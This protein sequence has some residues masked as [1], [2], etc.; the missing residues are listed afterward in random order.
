MV[1]ACVKDI[2]V[3]LLIGIFIGLSL[4]FVSP[5]ILVPL[6]VVIA[7]LIFGIWLIFCIEPE[8][9]TILVKIFTAGLALRLTLCILFAFVSC[10][11]R[12]HVFFLGADDYGFSLNASRIVAAWKDTGYIPASNSLTWM[13]VAGDLNYSYL[14]SYLYYF[15]GE[16]HFMPL[17]INCSLG[18]LS[19]ILIY[20]LAKKIYSYKVAIGTALFFAFWPSLVLWSTQNLKES[21]TIFI[22]L[23]VF[24]CVRELRQ[25]YSRITYWVLLLSS[26]ALIFKIRFSL[27]VFLSLSAYVS[28]FLF[29]GRKQLLLGLFGFFIVYLFFINNWFD[30]QTTLIRRFSLD[31]S[32]ILKT[33][34]HHHQAKTVSAESAFLT[35]IDISKPL[36]FISYLPLFLLYIFFSPFPWS[37]Y[38]L[39]QLFAGLEMLVWYFLIIF[40]LKG[41][42]LTLRYKL[43]ESLMLLFFSLMVLSAS[44]GEGNIGTLFRHRALIWPCLFIFISVGL[45]YHPQKDTAAYLSTDK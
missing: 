2:L 27:F 40:A 38:K 24:W 36:N 26:L 41:L 4:V 33:F 6:V 44:F 9:P 25:S 15:I 21:I 14:L 12:G 1:K 28:L 16:Y 39:N 3:F 32:S 45:F 22:I 29:S 17:F 34:Q 42:F 11:K 43:R 23:L 30:I 35:D 7:G 18:A 37:I 19:I 5:A 31:I 8:K 20:L 13:L 10:A